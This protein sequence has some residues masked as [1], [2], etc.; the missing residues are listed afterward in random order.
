MRVTNAMYVN[1]T[2]KELM[3]LQDRAAADMREANRQPAWRRSARASFD[4]AMRTWIKI[5][6]ELVA[7]GVLR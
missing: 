4:Q 3:A 6:N 2:D 7:R 5:G 1:P